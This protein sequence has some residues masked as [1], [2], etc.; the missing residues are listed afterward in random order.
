MRKMR[1]VSVGKLEGKEP[2]GRTRHRWEDDIKMERK[3]IGRKRVDWFHLAQFLAGSYE[4]G[5]TP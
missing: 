5:N 2:V 1:N 3:E 4:H